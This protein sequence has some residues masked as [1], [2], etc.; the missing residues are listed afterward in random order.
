MTRLTIAIPTYDRNEKAARQVERLLE[1]IRAED[2]ADVELLVVDNAS[3]VPVLGTLKERG[4]AGES[5]LRVV[6]NP[7]NVGLSANLSRCFEHA[8]GEWVWLVGDDDEVLPGALGRVLSSMENGPSGVVLH[9]FSVERAGE[10][11]S[12]DLKLGSLREAC[13]HASDPWCFSNLLFISTSVYHRASCLPHLATAYHW[14]ASVA[15]HLVCLFCALR[16]GQTAVVHAGRI[17]RVVPAEGAQRWNPIRL[18]MG[19][20]TLSEIEGCEQELHRLFDALMRRWYG[21]W[22]LPYISMLLCLRSN[23]PACFWKKWYFRVAAST[24]GLQSVVQVLLA[25]V[26]APVGCS[27]PVRSLAGRLRG[28]R[29]DSAGIGRM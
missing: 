25:F 4:L 23:R 24:S 8:A 19:L 18:R 5:C 15:P 12:V 29:D 27:A 11:K 17:A 14:N 6:C 26:W 10:Q 20:Q 7:A 16:D 1:Q 9:K 2:T 22:K 3:P 13:D 28:S 21:G